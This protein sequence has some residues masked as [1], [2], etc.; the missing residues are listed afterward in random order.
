MIQAKLSSSWTYK[1]TKW[2]KDDF[3]KHSVKHVIPESRQYSVLSN[4]I[5]SFEKLW[6]LCDA[7]N[8]KDI[9]C[10]RKPVSK[11]CAI[12]PA[13]KHAHVVNP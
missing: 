11:N 10:M 6:A 3:F 2:T 4:L 5:S 12:K 7:A 8:E 9:D 1:L 13:I